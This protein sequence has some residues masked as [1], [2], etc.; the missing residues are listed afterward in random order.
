MPKYV[1]KCPKCEH[2]EESFCSIYEQIKI[3]KCKKCKC[4]MNIEIQPVSFKINGKY[5][6][7]TGYS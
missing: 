7:K 1:Y 5:T 3:L 2:I 4:K 6:A